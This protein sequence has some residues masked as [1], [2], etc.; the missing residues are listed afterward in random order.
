MDLYK[1]PVKEKKSFSPMAPLRHENIWSLLVEKNKAFLLSPNN[2]IINYKRYSSSIPT[3]IAV[4]QILFI[5]SPSSIAVQN[6]Q[7]KYFYFELNYILYKIIEDTS[8]SE[9]SDLI[10]NKKLMKN[11][12]VEI[13]DNINWTSLYSGKISSSNLFENLKDW[14][15][16]WFPMRQLY[17]WPEIILVIETERCRAIECDKLTDNEKKALFTLSSQFDKRIS[18]LIYNCA[19]ILLVEKLRTISYDHASIL[20]VRV[21]CTIFIHSSLSE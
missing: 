3:S 2:R 17:S 1:T 12:A 11:N 10:S 9:L 8:E 13:C 5:K 7:K 21:M 19:K 14:P 20:M 4:N 16:T 18:S 6:N 15:L